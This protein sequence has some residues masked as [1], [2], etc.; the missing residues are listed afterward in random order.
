VTPI[1]TV[2][3]ET[4]AP[5]LAPTPSPTPEII[6]RVYEVDVDQ[7]YG[8]YRVVE[9]NNTPLVYENLTLNINSGDTVIWINDATPDWELTIVSEQGLWDNT[10]G[11]LRWNYQKINYTFKEPGTYGVYVREYPR[12]KHQKIVVSP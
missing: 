10:S 9:K 11:R 4:L 3:S 5:T 7:D 12:L 6:P 8:F 1:P 2:I